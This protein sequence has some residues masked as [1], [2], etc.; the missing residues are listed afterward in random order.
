VSPAQTPRHAEWPN[1]PLVVF[2]GLLA[3]LLFAFLASTALDIWGGRVVEQWQIQRSL[4]LPL[5]SSVRL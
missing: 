4:R 2:A 1:G 5:L 3:G